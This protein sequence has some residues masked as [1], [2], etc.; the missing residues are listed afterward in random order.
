MHAMM[1]AAFEYFF[2]NC[3]SQPT[4]PK[5]MRM[6]MPRSLNNDSESLMCI[7]PSSEGP[8]RMPTRICPITSG[9]C[10]LRQ[11]SPETVVSIKMAHSEMMN[12]AMVLAALSLRAS[13]VRRTARSVYMPRARR[14]RRSPVACHACSVSFS[15]PTYSVRSVARRFRPPS[16]FH[17]AIAGRL[18]LPYSRTASFV[19]IPPFFGVG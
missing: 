4:P 7:T 17:I 5:N 19:G 16:Q 12:V 15:Y 2:S 14:T 10:A 1:T 8:T 3:R 6:M 9:S 11:I 18:C 13:Y